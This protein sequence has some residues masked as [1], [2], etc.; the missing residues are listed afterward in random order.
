MKNIGKS[1]NNS[2]QRKMGPHTQTY[3]SVFETQGFG[4]QRTN[5]NINK[6]TKDP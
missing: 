3:P 2:L 6:T 4:G 5:T 1:R